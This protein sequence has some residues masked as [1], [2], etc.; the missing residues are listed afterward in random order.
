MTVS[1]GFPAIFN[2]RST[3]V[4]L[5]SIALVFFWIYHQVQILCLLLEFVELLL[6][7][8]LGVFRVGPSHY[9]GEII[10]ILYQCYLLI[11]SVVQSGCIQVE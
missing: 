4:D 1:T 8:L 9:K 6:R 11:S 7:S 10:R 2:P 3:L 5:K